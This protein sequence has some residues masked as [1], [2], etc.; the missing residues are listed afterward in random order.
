MRK[1]FQNF[2]HFIHNCGFKINVAEWNPLLTSS[3]YSWSM[4]ISVVQYIFE[5]TNCAGCNNMGHL[6]FAIKS[7]CTERGSVSSLISVNDGP[8]GVCIWSWKGKE[9]RWSYLTGLYK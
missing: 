5:G 2:Y 6:E 9:S 4:V 8:G 3:V 7:E 1:V